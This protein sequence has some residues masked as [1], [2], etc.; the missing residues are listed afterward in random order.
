LR[1]FY[2]VLDF[3]NNYIV[4]GLNLEGSGRKTASI[5][6]PLGPSNE[7]KRYNSGFLAF[8][9]LLLMF[10]CLITGYIL[11]KKRRGDAIRNPFTKT[12]ASDLKRERGSS[13][14]STKLDE[15]NE[16]EKQILE[17]GLN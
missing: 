5:D 12:K 4:L 16:E 7:D 1:N 3:D 8:V 6:N 11:Y 17:V 13:V 10:T 9:L 14:V 2:T 15:D